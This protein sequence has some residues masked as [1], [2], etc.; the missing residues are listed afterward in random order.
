MSPLIAEYDDDIERLKS[1][2]SSFQVQFLRLH[3]IKILPM[4]WG[5]EMLK[6]VMMYCIHVCHSIWVARWCNG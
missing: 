3:I 2:I 4:Y 5:E 1:Q 6:A